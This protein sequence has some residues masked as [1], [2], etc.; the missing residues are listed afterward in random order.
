MVP[1]Y[2]VSP[3]QRPS[4]SPE[5]KLPNALQGSMISEQWVGEGD[6]DPKFL[7]KASPHFLY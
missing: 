7:K 6:V 1:I 2:P 5:N 4:V 3:N